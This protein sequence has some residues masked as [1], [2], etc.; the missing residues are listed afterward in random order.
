MKFFV[1]TISKIK[2]S[3]ANFFKLEFRPGLILIKGSLKKPKSSFSRPV[4]GRW[5]PSH[6]LGMHS[7]SAHFCSS[8]SRA[9]REPNNR[10]TSFKTL[11]SSA[12]AASQAKLVQRKRGESD[13]HTDQRGLQSSSIFKTFFVYPYWGSRIYKQLKIQ[14]SL[15]PLR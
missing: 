4:P 2:T 8:I 10:G 9:R 7:C 3:E 12:A 14:I 11:L 15:F 5:P 13:T 6:W 1:E